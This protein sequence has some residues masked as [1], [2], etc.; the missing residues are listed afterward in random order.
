[1]GWVG[2]DAE[3]KVVSGRYINWT[4]MD[5]GLF[6]EKDGVVEVLHRF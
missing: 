3:V 5:K 1:M 6:M 4:G 2:L